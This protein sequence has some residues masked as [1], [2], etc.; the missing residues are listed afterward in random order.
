MKSFL[1]KLIFV[2]CLAYSNYALSQI[3]SGIWQTKC[4]AGIEKKQIY[5]PNN[6]V[7]TD[8]YFYADRNCKQEVMRF[9]TAGSVEYP[10]PLNSQNDSS[11]REINFSYKEI[12]LSL[13]TQSTID[14]FNSRQVCGFSDWQLSVAKNITGLKCALFNANLKT[15][16][17]FEG[18]IRYGIYLQ[19]EN[20]LYYGQ[21]TS[22]KNSSSPDRRPDQLNLTI[23][24]I[25]QNSL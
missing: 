6:S 1:N 17:P 18:D 8:E 11:N 24:Y 25:F 19:N 16:I 15:Q 10:T 12:Y 5:S 22:E 4:L 14:N 9:T 20:K 21:L 2:I 23:E 13:H 3:A 7:I